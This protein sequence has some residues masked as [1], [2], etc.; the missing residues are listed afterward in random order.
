MK[1]NAPNSIDW[2]AVKTEYITSTVSYR[3]LAEK[4][5]VSFR[6]MSVRGRSE[7]WVEARKQYQQSIAD[8]I[9]EKVADERVSRD[10]QKLLLLQKSADLMSEA[11]LKVFEDARAFNRFIVSDGNF[12]V[13]ER[14]FNKVDTKAMREITASIKD[15]TSVMRNV[16][17]LP[18]DIEQRQY[19]LAKQRLELD[20]SKAAVADDDGEETGV[21]VLPPAE[22]EDDDE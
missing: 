8:K 11:I 16:Y 15:L 6:Y 21:V 5:G 4:Y 2:A 14:V 10:A 7:G 12:S 18:T 3:K 17:N 9:I 22:S 1:K 13:E 20:K 19:D